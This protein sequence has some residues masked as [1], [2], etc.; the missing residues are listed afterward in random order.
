MSD[1]PELLR[2]TTEIVPTVAATAATADADR[3]VSDHVIAALAEAGFARHFVPARWGGHEGG[4]TDLCAAVMLL[5]EHCPSTAW[6]ASLAAVLGRIAGYLPHDGQRRIWSGSPDT[7]VVGSLLP[8]GTAVAVEGGWMVGGRW[9]YISSVE[10]SEWALVLAK[11]DSAD[12]PRARFF[13]VPRSAYSIEHTWNNVGMRATG[14]H[15]LTMDPTF[16]ATECSFD[17]ANLD[18]GGPVDA[19][20][21]GR[22]PLEAWA[23]LAFAPTVVGAAYGLLRA[24]RRAVRGKVAAG[25]Q[26]RTPIPSS[27]Y[28]M[29]LARS[30]GELDAAA[31]LVKRVASD[32]DTLRDLSGL[33]IA[34]C[35]RDCA[36][37]A[38]L[39]RTGADRLMNTAGTSA[40]ADDQP[41]QRFWRDVHSGSSH[42]MLQMPRAATGYARLAFAAEDHRP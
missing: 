8:L 26:S 23:G 5:A 16:V 37:A 15:T 39:A 2:R 4:L 13:A 3:R 21:G 17:R 24:W 7:L 28:E 19:A 38:E 14:S 36:L 31:L 20:G 33:E 34:A 6:L 29:A 11:T 12:G 22:M 42:V 1:E 30:A 35:A 40:L 10:F 9:P 18:L 25:A 27:T 32:V 41:L